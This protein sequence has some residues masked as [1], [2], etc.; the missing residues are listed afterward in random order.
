MRN[1]QNLDLAQRGNMPY[2]FFGPLIFDPYMFTTLRLQRVMIEC[3]AS[4]LAGIHTLELHET[5]GTILNQYQLSFATYPDIPNAPAMPHLTSLHIYG[6]NLIISNTPILPSFSVDSILSLELSNIHMTGSLSVFPIVSLFNI[7]LNPRLER[8]ILHNIDLASMH[9]FVQIIRTHSPK[10]PVLQS[11]TISHLNLFAFA[12]YI[13]PA[14]PAISSL[15]LINVVMNVEEVRESL[16]DIDL[17]PLIV[18]FIF[19]GV[20]YSRSY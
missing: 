20:E 18:T 4:C 11:L 7:T 9:Q 13:M 3:D 16:R 1:L 19:D 5:S 2:R 15:T 6:T 12:G 10:F 17:W 8:L 14:T